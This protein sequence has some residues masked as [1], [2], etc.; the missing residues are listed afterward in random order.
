MTENVFL[1]MGKRL[2]HVRK[3]VVD[4]RP[5]PVSDEKTASHHQ[6]RGFRTERR[7]AHGFSRTL[8]NM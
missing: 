7:V 8:T 2:F 1:M 3:R 6:Q 4:H 5:T